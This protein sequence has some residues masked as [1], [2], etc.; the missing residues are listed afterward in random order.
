MNCDK[1]KQT[2]RQRFDEAQP[3]TKGFEKHLAAC[4]ACRAYLDRLQALD[5]ALGQ[6]R[7]EG[8]PASLTPHIQKRLVVAS[9]RPGVG[10][11]AVGEGRLPW[12]SRAV[13]FA[14]VVVI[15][16]AVLGWFFPVAA[17]P[18]AWLAKLELWAPHLDVQSGLAAVGALARTAWNQ[19][20]SQLSD[21]RGL[22]ALGLWTGLVV[23][24]L[25][26]AVF[27]RFEALALSAD[28]EDPRRDQPNP[29]PKTR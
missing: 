24:A 27:N 6:L 17:E 29:A 4:P 25:F 18:H 16:A 26:L 10:R 12:A 1:V 8:P 22:S 28:A 2:L 9:M 20:T 3:V 13:G 14:A 15:A 11:R 5:G 21:V 19:T 23:M 7:L